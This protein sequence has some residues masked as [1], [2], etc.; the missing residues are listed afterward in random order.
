MMKMV[1]SSNSINTSMSNVIQFPTSAIK[2]TNP[3]LTDADRDMLLLKEK[4]SQVESA[5]EY[6]TTEAVSMVHRLGFDI[7]KEDYIKDVTMIVDSIRGLM[8]RASELDYPIHSWVDE[9]YKISEDK[10]FAYNPL[11]FT[12]D[13]EVTIGKDSRY[14]TVDDDGNFIETD[15]DGNPLEDK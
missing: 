11:W 12:E 15:K 10:Q 2:T 4:I 5:L 1:A 6:V 7:T 9:N 13:G 8:Y 14:A 3:R